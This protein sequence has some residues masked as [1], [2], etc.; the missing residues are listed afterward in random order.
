MAWVRQYSASNVV[1][2]RKLKALIFYTINPL[3]YDKLSLCVFEPSLGRGLG[4]TYAVHLRLIGKPV[5][6]FLLVIVELF[7][8]RCYS[9]GATSEYL[10]EV[11][12]FEGVGHFG[13]KFRVQRDVPH[14]PFV[15]G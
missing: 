4:A 13:P 6:D 3:L 14:Q 1:G 10:S 12:F 11:A 15:H 7:F 9:S 2:A 8:A 5:V